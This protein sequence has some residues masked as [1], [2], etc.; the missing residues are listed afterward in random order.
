LRKP[1]ADVADTMHAIE[2]MESDDARDRAALQ[3]R[4][5]RP[6]P[7]FALADHGLEKIARVVDARHRIDPRQ[8]PPQ[9]LA[10]RVRQ[11]KQLARIV[12][13]HGPQRQIVRNDKHN[14]QYAFREYVC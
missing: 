1:I 7:G 8:P 10:I 14:N 12:E 4:I 11:R 5:G 3:Y 13:R 2:R 9:V 6:E